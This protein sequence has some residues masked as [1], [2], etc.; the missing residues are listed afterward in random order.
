M[1]ERNDGGPAFPQH[2][3]ENCNDAFESPNG[4][5]LR[6]WFA[7]QAVASMLNNA[8]SLLLITQEMPS[9]ETIAHSVYVLA[10]AMLAEREKE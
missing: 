4:M 6:D 5:S 8:K 9:A 7:G 10:D 1:M 3:C 2:Y